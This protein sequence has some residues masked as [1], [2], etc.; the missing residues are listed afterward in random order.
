MTQMSRYYCQLIIF[1]GLKTMQIGARPEEQKYFAFCTIQPTGITFLS[2]QSKREWF[3]LE[4]K[5]TLELRAQQE[6]EEWGHEQI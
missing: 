4:N 3:T 5:T 6:W 1:R 2:T